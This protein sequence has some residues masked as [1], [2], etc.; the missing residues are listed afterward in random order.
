ME[1]IK[2]VTVLSEKGFKAL[3]DADPGN[4]FRGLFTE[5]NMI[6]LNRTGHDF[7]A[8]K[9]FSKGISAELRDRTSGLWG[10]DIIDSAIAFYGF[11]EANQHPMS[12]GSAFKLAETVGFVGVNILQD[13]SLTNAEFLLEYEGS[14]R[15]LS[16]G[17]EYVELARILEGMEKIGVAKGKDVVRP[18]D[19][20]QVELQ[21]DAYAANN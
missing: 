18:Y 8:F 13:I 19:I 17:Y 12:I 1:A 5:S 20:I 6:M 9:E 10:A 2:S 7:G 3:E 4:I 11:N 14:L 16:Y 15:R 21:A